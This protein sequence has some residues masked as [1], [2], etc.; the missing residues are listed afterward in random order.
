MIKPMLCKMEEKPFY[1]SDYIWEPKYDG[2]RILASVKGGNYTLFSRTGKEKT[3]LFKELKF[4]IKH[5]ISVVLDGE[6][7]S[8]TSFSNIQHRI[9]RV[10]GIETTAQEFPIKY[11]VFDVMFIGDANVMTFPLYKRKQVLST[12]ITETENVKIAPYT[13]DGVALFE[14]MAENNLEGV[15]GK[16]LQGV[17]RPDKREWLKVKCWQT[18]D[19]VVAGYT[20]GTGK[21]EDTFGALVLTNFQGEYVGL[22]GTGFTDDCVNMLVRSYLRNNNYPTPIKNAPNFH[23]TY[24]Q[25]PF[26]VKVQYL[27]YTNVGVLRFPSFKGLI[28]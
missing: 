21:R 17:Y 16:N 22:V 12:L 18:G 6:I 3:A 11:N 7:T 19:F 13:Q 15:V 10:K 1:S 9:N 2:A 28:K 4:D 20:P 8:G 26:P 5:D 24:I 25:T 14:K 23:I 27:E